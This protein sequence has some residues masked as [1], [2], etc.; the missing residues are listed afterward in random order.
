MILAHIVVGMMPV[1]QS[2]FSWYWFIG[3]VI[4]DIDH[5]FVLWKYR[6]FSWAK[7]I[8]TEKF[9]DKYNIHFKTKYV[10]SI[11]GAVMMTLPVLLISREGA[12]YFFI[13]YLIH[14]ALDW[15]DID[16]KQYFYPLKIKVRGFLPIWSRPEIALTITLLGVYLYLS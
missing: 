15:L 5:I 8:D 14:L 10:H 6:I 9:E 12:I 4:T 13:A 7:L 3:S 2:E 1:N 16:E 11:F